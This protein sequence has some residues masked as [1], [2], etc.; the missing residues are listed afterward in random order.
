MVERSLCYRYDGI[1]VK[2]ESKIAK[3]SE[4]T[5]LVILG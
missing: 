1:Y 3:K 5:T 4:I 2:Y